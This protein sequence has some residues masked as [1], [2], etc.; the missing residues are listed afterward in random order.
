MNDDAREEEKQDQEEPRRHAVAFAEEHE[1]IPVDDPLYRGSSSNSSSDDDEDEDD[2]DDF[3]LGSPDRRRSYAEQ[4]KGGRRS[5]ANR[6]LRTSLVTDLETGKLGGARTQTAMVGLYFRM[7]AKF[8]A[9]FVAAI[10]L[11]GSIVHSTFFSLYLC[12]HRSA[13]AWPRN[14]RSLRICVGGGNF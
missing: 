14:T 6:S 10:A 12:F 9:G 5:F 8:V 2:D 3:V 4:S 11:L 13:D 1:E 7:S